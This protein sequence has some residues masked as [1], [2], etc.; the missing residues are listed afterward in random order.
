MRKRQEDGE[1][2][3]DKIMDLANLTGA[4]LIFGQFATSQIHWSG[5]GIGLVVY[6]TAVI[7]ATLLRK[8][9]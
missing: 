3:A 6:G 1:F 5:I 2:W 7:I 8:R 4:V 9:R